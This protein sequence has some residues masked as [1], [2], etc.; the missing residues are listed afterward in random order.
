VKPLCPI[1][2]VSIC[3][4]SGSSLLMDPRQ[5]LQVTPVVWSRWRSLRS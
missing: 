1:S 3:K 5:S 2:R 4:S